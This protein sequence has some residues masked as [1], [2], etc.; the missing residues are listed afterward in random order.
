MTDRLAVMATA[1]TIN[2]D[3]A[4]ARRITFRSLSRTVVIQLAGRME[5][6]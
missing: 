6:E 2:H 5:A 4:G 3:S 1:T